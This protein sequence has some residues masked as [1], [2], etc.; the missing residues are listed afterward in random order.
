[1]PKYNQFDVLKWSNYEF[2]I[3]RVTESKYYYTSI[4]TITKRERNGDCPHRAIDNDPNLVLKSDKINIKFNTCK[5][6]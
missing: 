3:Y 6:I 4:N 1:M 2:I 5:V